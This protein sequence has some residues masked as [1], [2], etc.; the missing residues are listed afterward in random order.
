VLDVSLHRGLRAK[1]RARI[2]TNLSKF[3][4]FKRDQ[5]A[6]IVHGALEESFT[7]LAVLNGWKATCLDTLDPAPLVA[8]LQ[9]RQDDV[10]QAQERRAEERKRLQAL[11]SE[12]KD[13][14]SKS[15][16]EDEAAEAAVLDE[17]LDIPELPPAPRARDTRG[18]RDGGILTSD[19]EEERQKGYDKRKKAPRSRKG[20]GGRKPRSK[21]ARKKR[22]VT[23]AEGKEEK[24]DAP[25]S[26]RSA[27][28]GK[29]KPHL[30]WQL[31]EE[32]QG[33][34]KSDSNS[35][36]ASS[37]DAA[38]AD[39][40]S[41]SEDSLTEQSDT[42]PSHSDVPLE[43]DGE[44]EVE[45]EAKGESVLGGDGEEVMGECMSCGDPVFATDNAVQCAGCT[46]LAH[47]KCLETG[48]A[49]TRTR[50]QVFRC[51]ACK[52]QRS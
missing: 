3:L 36:S 1:L 35:N 19:A 4:V 26:K 31:V 32:D 10:K 23:A 12:A 44:E 37:R 40:S 18:M 6:G 34:S 39:E 22:K 46:G 38:A 9:K 20:K 47:L 45:Q 15:A 16:L 50:Q 11:L 51:G 21:P 29:A 17:H 42:E 2:G 48:R 27:A 13:P 43:S 8:V 33:E 5:V 49:S 14:E 7:S 52:S 24:S 25:E 28:K 41:D 30:R